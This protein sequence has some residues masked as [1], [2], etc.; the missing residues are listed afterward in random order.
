MRIFKTLLPTIWMTSR[1]LN[2][3]NI[4]CAKVLKRQKF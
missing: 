4:R 1:I 3:L 2:G